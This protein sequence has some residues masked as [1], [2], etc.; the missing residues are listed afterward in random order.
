M[1]V[2]LIVTTDNQ[3]GRDE[4]L[5]EYRS[6]DGIEKAFDIFKNENGQNRLHV[7]TR[8]QAEGRFFLAFLALIVS[9]ELDQRMRQSE[10]YKRFTVAEVMAELAKIR[11]LHMSD[12]STRLLEISKTQRTILEKLQVPPIPENLVII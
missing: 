4:T 10:L 1:G 8:E 6:R 12:G 5:M 2:T 9:C 3:L 7:S 11:Q